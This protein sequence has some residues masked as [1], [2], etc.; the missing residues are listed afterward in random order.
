MS[1]RRR[2]AAM[3]TW[4]QVFKGEPVETLLEA[5]LATPTSGSE[6]VSGGD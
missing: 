6:E 5:E 4:E 2:V 3:E 1:G